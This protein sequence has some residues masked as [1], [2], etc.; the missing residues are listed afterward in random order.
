[1]FVYPSELKALEINVNNA[2]SGSCFNKP[3]IPNDLLH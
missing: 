3:H 2:T 1:M